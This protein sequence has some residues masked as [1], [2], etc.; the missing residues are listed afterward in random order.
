MNGFRCQVHF[1][2]SRGSVKKRGHRP[3]VSGGRRLDRKCPLYRESPRGE[4][5]GEDPD[6]LSLESRV[7][8]V[9]EKK[10]DYTF[11]SGSLP[12]TRPDPSVS[13]RSD[14]G[15][16]D[17]KGRSVKGNV[18]DWIWTREV[19]LVSGVGMR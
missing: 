19:G 5:S 9:E 11:D 2:H 15:F 7:P 12:V 16:S 3:R 6:P 8:Q 1:P 10:K 18:N 13:F 4:I 17:R 14:L